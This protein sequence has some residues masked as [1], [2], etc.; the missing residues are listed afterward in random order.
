MLRRLRHAFLIAAGVF[1]AAVIA[2]EWR[3][4]RHA[5]RCAAELME[6]SRAK[7]PFGD[8]LTS[9]DL[10]A[11]LHSSHAIELAFARPASEGFFRVGFVVKRS[12][13]STA[14]ELVTLLLTETALPDCRFIGD[15]GQ[16]GPFH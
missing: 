8:L 1:V 4:S 14:A 16:A 2:G 3:M 5:D 12:A 6:A 11:S 9:D 10:Q 15:Y 7:R 13:T